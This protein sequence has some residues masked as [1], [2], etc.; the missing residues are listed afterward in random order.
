MK[1]L[2]QSTNLK[3]ILRAAECNTRAVPH[4]ESCLCLWCGET[5]PREEIDLE[6]L[7]VYD[8]AVCPRC[9]YDAMLPSASRFDPTEEQKAKIRDV[10]SH[11]VKTECNLLSVNHGGITLEMLLPLNFDL[12]SL[13][14]SIIS[15]LNIPLG[16]LYDF[17]DRSRKYHFKRPTRRTEKDMGTIGVRLSHMDIEGNFRMHCVRDMTI[18]PLGVV[19][20]GEVYLIPKLKSVTGEG[21]S[22]EEAENRLRSKYIKVRNFYWRYV[23][24]S[25]T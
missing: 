16:E 24:D 4:S 9:G 22:L 3:R 23:P 14:H 17:T 18:T 12:E 1:Y 8:G 6:G 21:L 10:I 25:D 11:G 15:I 19:E 7:E 13:A 20:T 5:V 2:V